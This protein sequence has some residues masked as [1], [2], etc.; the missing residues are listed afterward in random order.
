MTTAER[1]IEAPRLPRAPSPV[2]AAAAAEAAPPRAA[3]GPGGLWATGLLAAAAWVALGLLTLLWPNKEVGFSDWAFT[4]EF[5]VA[6]L[7]VA[8]LLLEV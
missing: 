4:R 5:G 2:V 8:A 7:V 3:A 6:A 1:F